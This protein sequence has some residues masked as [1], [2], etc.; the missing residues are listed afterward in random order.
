MVVCWLL[1]GIVDNTAASRRKTRARSPP[2]VNR[3]RTLRPILV[4]PSRLVS[5]HPVP[6]RFVSSRLDSSRFV[7]FRFVSSFLS[8]LASSKV[9]QRRRDAS[10]R[11]RVLHSLEKQQQ[12]PPRTEEERR[13]AAGAAA[14]AAEVAAEGAPPTPAPV[15]IGRLREER[16]S[17]RSFMPVERKR[18]REGAILLGGQRRRKTRCWRLVQSSRLDETAKGLSE[19]ERDRRWKG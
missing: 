14:G 5:S 3:K 1:A 18:E 4:V 10:R 11:R 2:R 16:A 17:V 19:R 6:S 12:Q 13:A 9:G 8:R 15:G 7:S